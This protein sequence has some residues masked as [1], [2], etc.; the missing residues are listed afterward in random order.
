MW[1]A[2][3]FALRFYIL[4]ARVFGE[5]TDASQLRRRLQVCRPLPFPTSRATECGVASRWLPIWF[6]L[7]FFFFFT[8]DLVFPELALLFYSHIP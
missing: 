5:A 4:P 1:H 3:A 8:V 7:V 6:F 2:P